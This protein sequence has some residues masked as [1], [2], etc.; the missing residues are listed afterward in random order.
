MKDSPASGH[1]CSL[2]SALNLA[3]CPLALLTGDLAAAEYFVTMLLDHSAR[4]GLSRWYNSGRCFEGVLLTKQGDIGGG[5]Q[6][7]RIALNEV[8]ETGFVLHYT[9]FLGALA[10]AFAA[11]EDAAPGPCRNR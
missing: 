6:R 7:L 3:A 1:A 11:I 2:C 4:H 10:E 8:R 9:A 5:L